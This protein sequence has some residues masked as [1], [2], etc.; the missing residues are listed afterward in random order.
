MTRWVVLAVIVDWHPLKRKILL[1]D[2]VNDAGDT[3]RPSFSMLGLKGAPFSR[4]PISW[5]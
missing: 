5:S 1:L 3:S 4:F 2:C